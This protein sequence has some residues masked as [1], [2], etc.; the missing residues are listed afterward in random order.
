MSQSQQF[1]VDST[2][3]SVKYYVDN[4]YDEYQMVKPD[5]HCQY[6][7]SNYISLGRYQHNRTE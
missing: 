7:N 5:Q 2:I 1:K 6:E 3:P 4:T